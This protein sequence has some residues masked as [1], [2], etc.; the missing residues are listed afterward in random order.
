MSIHN[1][2]RNNSI[3]GRIDELVN[4]V[5]NLERSRTEQKIETPIEEN[6]MK[7]VLVTYYDKKTVEVFLC[8]GIGETVYVAVVNAVPRSLMLDKIDFL[9]D[10]TDI[11]AKATSLGT[12]YV[13]Q[14][15]LQTPQHTEGMLKAMFHL[16]KDILLEWVEISK[17]AYML[18]TT[19]VEG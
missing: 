14:K 9:Q 12:D 19:V 10:F 13:W 16:E 3:N 18:L 17:E 7:Y 1:S 2:E 4:R 15:F 8:K 6:K 11:I 5:T